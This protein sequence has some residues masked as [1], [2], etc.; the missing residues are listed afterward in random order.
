MQHLHSCRELCGNLHL[1][2]QH[3]ADTERQNRA[4]ALSTAQQAVTSSPAYF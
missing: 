3:I 2:A 1:A 4:D